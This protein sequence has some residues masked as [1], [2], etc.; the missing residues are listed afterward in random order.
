M[1]CHAH[2]S[3]RAAYYNCFVCLFICLF[4][5]LFVCLSVAPLRFSLSGPAF[6]FFS[7]SGYTC[8][9]NGFRFIYLKFDC[10]NYNF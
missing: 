7:L 9:G 10:L 1:Q 4:V 6:S 8:P 5:R 3:P 2:L